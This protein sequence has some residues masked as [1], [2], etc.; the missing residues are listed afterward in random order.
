MSTFLLGEVGFFQKGWISLVMKRC[1]FIIPLVLLISVAPVLC[2]CLNDAAKAAQSAVDDS[3]GG[4]SAHCATHSQKKTRCPDA[5]DCA[6]LRVI[7]DRG[8]LVMDGVEGSWRLKDTIC[9]TSCASGW[10]A[11]F[12]KPLILFEPLLLLSWHS[13]EAPLFIVHHTFRL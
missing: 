4:P 12:D 5:Q 3:G 10:L 8:P 6:C 11:G 9:Q 7:A 2:C 1:F 13:Q